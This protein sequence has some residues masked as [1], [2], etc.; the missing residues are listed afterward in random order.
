MNG[1]TLTFKV[2]CA[3]A[4]LGSATAW[5]GPSKTISQVGF[6]TPLLIFEKNENRQNLMIV[7]TRLDPKSCEFDAKGDTPVLDYYWMMN[8]TDYK[9]VHPLILSSVKER[10]EVDTSAFKTSKKF[11][12]HLKEFN[13]LK[14]DLG[15]SPTFEVK[16]KKNGSDCEAT[17]EMQLGPSDGNRR[18]ALDSIYAESSKTILPPF[19][20]LKALTINGKDLKTGEIVH[21]TY[22]AN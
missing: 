15:T 22:T 3:I 13:E 9:K 14:S 1:E 5:A 8:G 18:V 20:K 16:S 4:L 12:V 2:A 17:V 7:Y 19:R 11:L 6:H 10:L 21:R